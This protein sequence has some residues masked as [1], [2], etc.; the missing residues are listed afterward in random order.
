MRDMT[1]LILVL[2]LAAV[3]YTGYF[4]LNKTGADSGRE[5]VVSAAGL[6]GFDDIEQLIETGNHLMDAQRYPE[7][8]S[9]YSRVL[10]LDSTLVDVRVD[11][12]S[13][14]FAT[15]QLGNA[16]MDFEIAL[17]LQPDHP[18]ACFNLGIVHGGLGNDSLM[19]HYWNQYL[20]I[21]PDGDLADRVRSFLEEHSNMPIDSA[22][23]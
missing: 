22:G 9:H 2:S 20:D 14:Y 23:R 12:G 15:D 11:R 5:S 7:A 19:L 1:I 18:I 16:L 17:G 3:G 8:I 4:I 6:E 21:E 10:E 13:C